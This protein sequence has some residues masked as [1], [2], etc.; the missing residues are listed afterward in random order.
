[1]FRKVY[2]SLVRQRLD[3][4][5]VV[6]NPKY[7]GAWSGLMKQQQQFA[8]CKCSSWVVVQTQLEWELESDVHGGV[9]AHV[10]R[11]VPALACG[12]HHW[13]AYRII[14]RDILFY[15][16]GKRDNTTNYL[17]ARVHIVPLANDL[18]V[19]RARAC[20]RRPGPS[21]KCHIRSLVLHKYRN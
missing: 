15:C 10:A 18:P 7:G 13:R 11:T 19:E 17:L 2:S 3:Y 16:K 21:V 12:W 1:M 9:T 6:W 20:D 14:Q 4:C 5:Y 8:V